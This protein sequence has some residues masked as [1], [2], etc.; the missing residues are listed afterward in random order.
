M[1][2][3]VTLKRHL[4]QM[5]DEASHRLPQERSLSQTQK[6]LLLAVIG[7]FKIF[8]LKALDD[9]TLVSFTSVMQRFVDDD[10]FADVLRQRLGVYV[11]RIA[12]GD[13]SPVQ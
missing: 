8:M 7:S 6:V 13:H 4:L 11:S 1:L 2:S 12:E 10:D 5:L 3:P 9:A